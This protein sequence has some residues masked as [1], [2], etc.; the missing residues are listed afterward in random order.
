MP[1]ELKLLKKQKC[2]Q[3]QAIKRREALSVSFNSGSED[4]FVIVGWQRRNTFC[5]K[6]A[7][8]LKYGRK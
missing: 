7:R 8:T 3:M 1:I 5:P 2:D 6:V 4:Q